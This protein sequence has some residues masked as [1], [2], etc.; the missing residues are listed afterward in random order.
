MS[1]T[2]TGKLK[3]VR[4]STQ[5]LRLDEG[6]AVHVG[7]DVHEGGAGSRRDVDE[8]KPFPAP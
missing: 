2:K 4:T 7:V 8:P 5:P 1:K 6:E 3:L